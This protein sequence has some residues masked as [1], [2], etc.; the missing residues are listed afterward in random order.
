[1]Q[2]RY[3][4]WSE[5]VRSRKVFTHSANQEGDS[6]QGSVLRSRDLQKPS[7]VIEGSANGSFVGIVGVGGKVNKGGPCTFLQRRGLELQ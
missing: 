3:V 2:E 6:A 4:G 1:M 7:V 5:I